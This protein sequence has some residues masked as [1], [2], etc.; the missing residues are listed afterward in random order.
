MNFLNQIHTLI[1]STLSKLKG[2]FKYIT[3][4][5]KSVF[6]ERMTKEII[7]GLLLGLTIAYFVP[8]ISYSAGCTLGFIFGFYKFIVK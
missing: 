5:L 2:F 4:I 1:L 6:E 7:G 3:P 8:F